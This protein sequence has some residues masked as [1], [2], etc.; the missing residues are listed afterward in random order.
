MNHR[1]GLVV[2]MAM[3]VT[4]DL[5]AEAVKKMTAMKNTV[6]RDGTP[7]CQLESLGGPDD[8][9]SVDAGAGAVA[10]RGPHSGGFRMFHS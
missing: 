7:G 8:A 2:V 10:V 1:V 3:V 4:P 5:R 6:P 9:G